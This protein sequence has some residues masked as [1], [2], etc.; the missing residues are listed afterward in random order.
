LIPEEDSLVQHRASSRFFEDI[1]RNTGMSDFE[2]EKDL[3]EKS[4]ILLW[5][6]KNDMRSLQELG[7]V[8]NLYYRNK[9]QLISSIAANNKTAIFGK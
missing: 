7:K 5:M 2:I 9:Q 8:I 1:S 6:V 4:N 3:K